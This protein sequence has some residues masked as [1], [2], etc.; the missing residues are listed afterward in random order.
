MDF[1]I[2]KLGRVEFSTILF[3]KILLSSCSIAYIS[4]KVACEKLKISG[5]TQ[6]TMKNIFFNQ[7]LEEIFN[8]WKTRLKTLSKFYVNYALNYKFWLAAQLKTENY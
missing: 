5:L 7:F 8:S 3:K 6:K 1:G 4:R 2:F